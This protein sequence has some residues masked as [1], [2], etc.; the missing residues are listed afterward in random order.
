[1]RKSYPLVSEQ[2]IPVWEGRMKSCPRFS[3][4]HSTLEHSRVRW[5][6]SN[7]RVS[8]FNVENPVQDR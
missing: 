8:H 4:Y 5:F 3:L 2:R 1:M 6:K 7:E